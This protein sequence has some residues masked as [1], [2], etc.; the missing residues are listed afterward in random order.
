[1]SL[2]EIKAKAR[3]KKAAKTGGA[4]RKPAAKCSSLVRKRDGLNERIKAIE[5]ANA[6]A[7]KKEQDKIEARHQAQHKKIDGEKAKQLEKL[8]AKFGQACVAKPRKPRSDKGRTK[9]APATPGEAPKAA[10]RPR[11][12]KAAKR[13]A[14]AEAPAAE[15]PPSPLGEARKNAAAKQK[16][17]DEQ[18]EL[19]CPG[20]C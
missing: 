2:A 14:K 3:A 17:R 7:M 11:A 10:S 15:G 16:R 18:Q 13:K 12:K 6:D 1:M 8:A 4:K 19:P 5:K 9:A 20:G